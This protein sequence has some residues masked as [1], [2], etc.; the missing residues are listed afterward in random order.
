MKN[1]KSILEITAL[2]PILLSASLSVKHSPAQSATP[3]L[4]PDAKDSRIQIAQSQSLASSCDAAFDQMLTS[5]TEGR[6]LSV[7]SQFTRETS[8]NYSDYPEGRSLLHTIAI[9]GTA[10]ASIMNSPQFLLNIS[11][12][13]FAGCSTAGAIT[14][15]N[16]NSVASVETIGLVDGQPTFFEC[17]QGIITSRIPWGYHDCSP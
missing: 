5:L 7:A 9:Q 10:S 12:S 3:P 4:W 2:L 1:M 13:F 14:I 8:E 17:A 11:E 6:S 16:L 15:V